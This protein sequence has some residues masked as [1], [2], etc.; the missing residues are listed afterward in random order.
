MPAHPSVM[1]SIAYVD[2]GSVVGEV[3][4]H[5]TEVNEAGKNASAK[6]SD[7]RRRNLCNIDGAYHWGLTNT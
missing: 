6:T 4:Q 2:L 3:G 1:R 5:D 7:G